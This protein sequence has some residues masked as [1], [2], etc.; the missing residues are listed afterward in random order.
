MGH[1]YWAEQ[2]HLLGLTADVLMSTSVLNKIWHALEDCCESS[3]HESL[4]SHTVVDPVGPGIVRC[5]S[6][7]QQGWAETGACCSNLPGPPGN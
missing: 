4:T 7:L 3:N 5:W 2:E 1:R 6:S